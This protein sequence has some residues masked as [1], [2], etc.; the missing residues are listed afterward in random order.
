VKISIDSPAYGNSYL[1]VVIREHFQTIHKLTDLVG[2]SWFNI[3][4]VL[5]ESLTTN[6]LE[7]FNNHCGLL[8]MN[9]T[10]RMYKHNGIGKLF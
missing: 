2:W 8:D 10:L 6:S 7:G 5:L 3:A 4:I 9:R 1:P